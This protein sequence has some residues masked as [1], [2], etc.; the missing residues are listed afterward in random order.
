MHRS[1]PHSPQAFKV[2]WHLLWFLQQIRDETEVHESQQKKAV[3]LVPQEGIKHTT[4][5]P[6]KTENVNLC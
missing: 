6:K 5:K 4:K 3:S 1:Q 2:L